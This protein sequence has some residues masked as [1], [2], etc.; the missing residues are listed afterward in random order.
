M[1][2]TFL[3]PG[4]KQAGEW[5]AHTREVELVVERSHDR[6]QG[7]AG[8]T[9]AMKQVDDVGFSAVTRFSKALHMTVAPFTRYYY[10]LAQLSER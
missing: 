2:V 3:D 4:E 10:F 8:F 7:A 9:S 6:A 1:G 5:N